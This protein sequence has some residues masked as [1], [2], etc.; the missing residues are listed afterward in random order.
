MYYTHYSF[1][2]LIISIILIILLLFQLFQKTIIHIILTGVLL[3]ILYCDKLYLLIRI[4]SIKII[5]CYTNYYIKKVQGGWH[6]PNST[7]HSWHVTVPRHCPRVDEPNPASIA[8]T[9]PVVARCAWKQ[10]AQVVRNRACVP[11]RDRHKRKFSQDMLNRDDIQ[12][13][14][15][16][17]KL[18]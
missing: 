14:F 13:G 1:F 5:Y 4:I 2:C 3:I 17:F 18:V 10:V 12:Y 16:V 11:N 6:G 9:R 7:S 15:S 8:S